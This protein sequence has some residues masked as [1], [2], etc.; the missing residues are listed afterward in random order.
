MKQFYQHTDK[1]H[2]FLFSCIVSTEVLVAEIKNKENFEFICSTKEEWTTSRDVKEDTV[3]LEVIIILIFS[4]QLHLWVE[5]I[6]YK[7]G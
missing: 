1:M 7:L 6:R 3:C 5:I 2:H 4:F